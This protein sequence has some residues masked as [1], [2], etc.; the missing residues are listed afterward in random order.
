MSRI[1]RLNTEVVEYLPTWFRDI[2]E[3]QEIMGTEAIQLDQLAS[4]IGNVNANFFFQTM[5]E[6]AVAKWESIFH[7]LYSDSET[8]EFRR[9]RL[10]NRISTR[11]P[12]TLTFLYQKLDELIGPDK[13]EVY[14]DY[15]N[16][17]LYIKSSAINQSYAQEIKI[18]IDKIKP[19][20]IVYTN[21]P[22]I[23]DTVELLEGIALPVLTYN[24]RL[25]NWSMGEFPFANLKEKEMVKTPNQKSIEN[26][27]LTGTATYISDNVISVRLNGSI[28]ITEI[29]KSLSESVLTISYTV[30]PDVVTVVTQI[31]LLDQESNVLTSADVYVPVTDPVLFEHTITVREGA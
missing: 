20:H 30:S 12:F 14:V 2:P 19:C 16:Y 23:S 8:L 5:D 3:F 26:T 9:A 4:Q 11:P 24:Y 13:W 27:L 6:R 28:I 7:I 15:P 22:L 29:T 18:T 17:T 10:L 1:D 31:E 21:T 25:G